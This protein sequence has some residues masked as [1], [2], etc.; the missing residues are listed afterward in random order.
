MNKITLEKHIDL[1]LDEIK[2]NNG[3]NDLEERTERKEYYQSFT[4]DI[5]VYMKVSS[6]I[7][8]TK[9]KILKD[10]FMLCVNTIIHAAA[11]PKKTKEEKEQAKKEKENKEKK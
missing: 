10:H 2:N 5:S 7:I 11:P 9:M 3:F 1:Y 8:S 6:T 4:K